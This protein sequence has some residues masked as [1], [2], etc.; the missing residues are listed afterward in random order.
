M[1]VTC[2]YPSDHPPAPIDQVVAD[3]FFDIEDGTTGWFA[4]KEMLSRAAPSAT[5]EVTQV[6]HMGMSLLAKTQTA[7]DICITAAWG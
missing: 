2:N 7:L 1:Y 6:E 4:F 3:S 5:S